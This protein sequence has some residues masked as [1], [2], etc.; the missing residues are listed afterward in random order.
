ME[1]EKLSS[2]AGMLAASVLEARVDRTAVKS[3][4]DNNCRIRDIDEEQAWNNYRT[5][6]CPYRFQKEDFIEK[7]FKDPKNTLTSNLA[8]RTPENSFV[9]C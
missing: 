2:V 6:H 7:P 5:F 1:E 3:V 9:F 8:N 4:R